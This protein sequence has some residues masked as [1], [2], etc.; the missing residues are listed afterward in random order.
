MGVER[1]GGIWWGPVDRTGGEEGE[2]QKRGHGHNSWEEEG[3]FEDTESGGKLETWPVVQE[4]A[5]ARKE[6]VQQACH[7]CP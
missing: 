7:C 5:P 6:Q 4:T 2:K 3:E 1:S